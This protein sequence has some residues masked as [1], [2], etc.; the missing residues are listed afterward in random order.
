[1]S[2]G[3]NSIKNEQSDT[4][5]IDKD[6]ELAGAIAIAFSP[7]N[8]NA[9]DLDFIVTKGLDLSNNIS[10]NLLEWCKREREEL[11]IV[12]MAAAYVAVHTLFSRYNSWL[13]EELAELQRIKIESEE[14]ADENVHTG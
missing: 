1:M 10:L 11:D 3:N 9:E 5:P 13:H 6:L 14:H 7:F 12:G 4:V 8:I 2:V